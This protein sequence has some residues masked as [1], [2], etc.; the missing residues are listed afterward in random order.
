M[1]RISP[2]LFLAPLLTAVAGCSQGSPGALGQAN[3]STDC[4]PEDEAC[5]A[6]GLDAPIA[7]GAELAL[8]VSTRFAGAA[9]LELTLEPVDSR[10]LEAS[11]NRLTGVQP[12][13]VALLV[14]APEARVIDFVHVSVREPTR[15]GIHQLGSAGGDLGEV[16]GTVQLLPGDRVVVDARPYHGERLLLGDVPLT[17]SA[18]GQAV[19][20]LD[21]GLGAPRRIVAREPGNAR[22]TVISGE[23]E[24]HLDLEVL[25]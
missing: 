14:R 15:L 22:V 6:S 25:Q 18:T 20:L 1:A 11:G 12:G 24:A 17:W 8:D 2:F 21:T 13:V 19:T 7:V 9:A 23:H 10:V 16:Q 4:A 3:F 5:L